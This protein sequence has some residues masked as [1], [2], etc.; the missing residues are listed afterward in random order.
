[1]K[2]S[3]TLFAIVLGAA[4][5]AGNA[6]AAAASA[7]KATADIAAEKWLSIPVVY[8]KVSKAGYVE[9]NEIERKRDGYKIK[10][11]DANG[12]L[13]KLF[14]DP[15]NGE[16]LDSKAKKSVAD[17]RGSSWFDTVF[18]DK[19]KQRTEAAAQ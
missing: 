5:F 16:V 1:M 18:T 8:D 14:V 11:T 4:V 12:N 17:K 10:A 2:T 19:G 3:H 15:L 6:Y 13:V 7:D 9:I